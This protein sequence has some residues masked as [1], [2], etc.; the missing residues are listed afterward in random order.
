MITAMPL[1]STDVTGLQSQL[2]LLIFYGYRDEIEGMGKPKNSTLLATTTTEKQAIQQH[3]RNNTTTQQHSSNGVNL[4]Q[5]LSP[6]AEIERELENRRLADAS[7]HHGTNRRKQTKPFVK[8]NSKLQAKHW[9][10]KMLF[11]YVILMSGFCLSSC[12]TVDITARRRIRTK[13]RATSQPTTTRTSEDTV[14]SF[15]QFMNNFFRSLT[16]KPV[17]DYAEIAPSRS[18]LS[19]LEKIS[20]PPQT[21]GLPRPVTLTIA[22]SVPTA[23]VWYGWYKVRGLTFITP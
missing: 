8:K 5:C 2:F 1:S 7:A 17:R 6:A 18:G 21:P 4:W 19:F 10:L 14:D 22:A 23:L 9:L 11:L 13:I 15:C 16:I 3:K 12:F 20:S